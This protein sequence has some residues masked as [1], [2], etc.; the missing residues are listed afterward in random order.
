MFPTT[1]EIAN[2]LAVLKAI[3]P[4]D[5]VSELAG[6]LG[7]PVLLNIN[8]LHLGDELG[9]FKYHKGEDKIELADD[10]AVESLAVSEIVQRLADEMHDLLVIENAKQGDVDIDTLWS[11]MGQVIPDSHFLIAAYRDDR[12]ETY[13]VTPKND[14]KTTYTFVTLKGN[15]RHEWGR[16]QIIEYKQEKK[17]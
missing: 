12:L 1:K 8:A 10:V 5:S 7:Y 14:K 13:T 16:K 11:W 3:Y 6:K 17:S 15:A 4:K 2:E 9:L